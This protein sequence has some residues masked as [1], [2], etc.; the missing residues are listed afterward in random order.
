MLLK[1]FKKLRNTFKSKYNVDIDYDTSLISD[2]I[3]NLTELTKI[4]IKG[5]EQNLG[6]VRQEIQ[7]YLYNMKIV[8]INLMNTDYL[9][10]KQ[11]ICNLK[12]SIDP[13]DVRLRKKDSKIDREIKHSFY[14]IPSNSRDLVIIGFDSEV[15]KGQAI[16]RDFLLR[17]NTLE[18]NQSLCFLC[19]TYLMNTIADFKNDYTEL[20]RSKNVHFKII[21][22]NYIRKHL[23]INLEG[24]WKDIMLVKNYLFRCF[25]DFYNSSAFLSFN[26]SHLASINFIPNKKKSSIYDFLQYTYNQE[27]KLISKNLR[28]FFI[29]KNYLI[30]NWDYISEELFQNEKYL[31]ET[32]NSV[33]LTNVQG[34]IKKEDYNNSLN[35]NNF[36]N[37]LNNTP[38]TINSNNKDNQ[39]KED[40]S[41]NNQLKTFLKTYDRDTSLNYML[42]QF[43]GD[44]QRYYG[45][46]QIDLCDHLIFYL[47]EANN[48][49]NHYRKDNESERNNNLNMN[50]GNNNFQKF[51]DKDTKNDEN[52]SLFTDPSEILASEYIPN[53]TSKLYKKSNTK[54]R[55][56]SRS[57]SRSNYTMEKDYRERDYYYRDMDRDFRENDS[58]ETQLADKIVECEPEYQFLDEVFIPNKENKSKIPKKTCYDT[59]NNK[60]ANVVDLFDKKNND[61]NNEEIDYFKNFLKEDLNLKNSLDENFLSKKIISIQVKKQIISSSNPKEKSKF[62]QDENI[63]PNNVADSENSNED[64]KSSINSNNKSNEI[65][66]L[67]ILPLNINFIPRS[68]SFLINNITAYQ[69]ESIDLKNSINADLNFIDNSKI[70]ISDFKIGN[71]KT[72]DISMDGTSFDENFINK[73]SEINKSFGNSSNKNYSPNKNHLNSNN[74]HQALLNNKNASNHS[75]SRSSAEKDSLCDENFITQNSNITN[76]NNSIPAVNANDMRNILYNFSNIN[77]MNININ[78][79]SNYKDLLQKQGPKENMFPN[80]KELE[81][82]KNLENFSFMKVFNSSL[83]NYTN[84]NASIIFNNLEVSHSHDI[85]LNFEPIDDEIT[86]LNKKIKSSDISLPNDQTLIEKKVS[87][88]INNNVYSSNQ[89]QII[90]NLK[91]KVNKKDPSMANFNAYEINN[92][93]YDNFNNP[94]RFDSAKYSSSTKYNKNSE[95]FCE[96]YSNKY[97]EKIDSNASYLSKSFLKSSKKTKITHEQRKRRSSS[98]RFNNESDSI[99]PDNYNSNLNKN[100]S[101]KDS[102]SIDSDTISDNSSFKTKDKH[103]ENSV[104]NYV[105]KRKKIKRRNEYKNQKDRDLNNLRSELFSP[106][107]SLNENN[108]NSVSKKSNKSSSKKKYGKNVI[109]CY[110][111]NLRCEKNS[112]EVSNISNNSSSGNNN[113][114]INSK[115]S[116]KV[117]DFILDIKAGLNKNLYESNEENLN[118][119]DKKFSSKQKYGYL[120]K[121]D[122][123]SKSPISNS[124]SVS[125]NA[126]YRRSRSLS[127]EK[128]DF[129]DSINNKNERVNT[130]LSITSPNYNIYDRRKKLQINNCQS[131]NISDINFSNT[132]KS[133][134]YGKYLKSKF[135]VI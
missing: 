39:D 30:K 125:K 40:E 29:E 12:T 105:Y 53:P 106:N 48:S 50:S 7:N 100:K 25:S 75:N 43:P 55:R 127:I 27:H 131:N 83:A 78:I 91:E 115:M 57:I 41:N 102:L 124:R 44:Y 120:R 109:S 63:N 80:S 5:L 121:K 13:A 65:K 88:E 66:N 14:Y 31:A 123:E 20:F 22:P 90:L 126:S 49:Y 17:Q 76:S 67:N 59:I 95:K 15:K 113:P 94:K 24:K 38:N 19:P 8:S 82:L 61:F 68:K 114:R 4:T 33:S 9:Y 52:K 119:L 26:T 79:N 117:D 96:K 77:Q 60:S 18:H 58:R 132:I 51:N 34:Q 89:D 32:K 92:I 112:K 99:P 3:F 69:E 110:K 101:R 45:M 107:L 103:R 85:K 6:K 10:V 133:N 128:E 46:S 73:I 129:F 74:M 71:L 54:K 86:L 97:Q 2:E 56:K 70:S 84:K 35:S 87:K 116:N 36:N 108:S 1:S 42:N 135:L 98:N 11:S 81:F 104:G 93:N 23:N 37:N 16:I 130:N 122:S 118:S 21:E 62:S 47:E 111:P 64:N 72:I 28:K 134:Y